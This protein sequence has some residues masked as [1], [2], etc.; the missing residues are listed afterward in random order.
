[1]DGN[2]TNYHRKSGF[3][4]GGIHLFNSNV[5]SDERFNKV[6]MQRWRNANEKAANPD[7][8]NE[9]QLEQE[10]ESVHTP[11][12]KDEVRVEEERQILN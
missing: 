2:T 7:Q 11:D 5:I 12:Q 1:M 4:K 3:A 8:V 10:V 6:D 9:V